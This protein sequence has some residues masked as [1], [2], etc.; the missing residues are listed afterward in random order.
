MAPWRRTWRDDPD[1]GVLM[2]ERGRQ[3]CRV[4][5]IEHGPQAGQWRWTARTRSLPNSGTAPTKDEAKAAA[6]ARWKEDGMEL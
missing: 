4:M 2:D 5:L 3:A 1:D 6:E